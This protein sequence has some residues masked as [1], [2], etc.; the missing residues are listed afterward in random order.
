MKKFTKNPKKDN[1]LKQFPETSIASCDIHQRCKINLSF[2]DPSQEHGADL[3]EL[4]PGLLADILEKIKTYNR[5]DL[6]FWRNQRCGGGGLKIFADYGA[7][8]P[9]SNFSRPK[10]IPHDVNWCRFRMENLSRLIGF[11]VPHDYQENQ[12]NQYPYDPNTFYLV[13]IDLEHNFYLTEKR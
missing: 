3:T 10:S 2:F 12:K 9:R 4:A 6:N 11:T 5:S 7:F 8:P 1:F 13:F